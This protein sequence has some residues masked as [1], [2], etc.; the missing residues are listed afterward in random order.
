MYHGGVNMITGSFSGVIELPPFDDREW[1]GTI[2]N[3]PCLVKKRRELIKR[4]RWNHAGP[5]IA[6]LSAMQ[7]M[8]MLLTPTAGFFVL[9]LVV[10]S[11][12]TVMLFPAVIIGFG[13]LGIDLHYSAESRKDDLYSGH[14]TVKRKG[15]SYGCMKWR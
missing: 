13:R 14:F 1:D 11:P 10:Q 4:L 2:R 7:W 8:N 9:F 6:V 15:R 5:R 12:W 3:S